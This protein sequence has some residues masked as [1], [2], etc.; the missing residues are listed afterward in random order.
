[1]K[2]QK[3]WL[4]IIILFLLDCSNDSEKKEI[5]FELVKGIL[6]FA[7]SEQT[8]NISNGLQGY[9]FDKKDYLFSINWLNNGLQLYDVG[10]EELIKEIRF[11]E[12]GPNGVGKIFG[13]YVH[14]FDSIFLFTQRNSEIILTDTSGI[15][16]N[17]ISYDPQVG[18]TNAFVHNSYFI[19]EPVIFGAKMIVKAHIEGNY[20]EMTQSNLQKFPLSYI[21]NL[22]TG[23]SETINATYPDDYMLEGMRFFEYSM[24]S[25]G[26]NL[27]FSF[28]GDH[29]VF[30]VEDPLD[31]LLSYSDSRSQYLDDALPLYPMNGG[32][33]DTYGYLFAS[34]HYESLL[35]DPF[36]EIYYRIAV[37]KVES[38]SEI[39][40]FELKSAPL[41][42]S[43]VVL[44]RNLELVGEY[45]FENQKYLPQNIF[46]G[47][48][49]L[50][51]STSHPSNKDIKEDFMVF[52]CLKVSF[53]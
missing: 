28:F 42:F 10:K 39:E 24:T 25:N 1:M 26:K 38:P 31:K 13:F 51:I 43:V 5:K 2:I 22:E 47:S 4:P 40:L 14:N 20:R 44:N 15:I 46:I 35:Y 21:I 8:S 12:Q 52:D 29:R 48:N 3:I 37:P 27:V 11:H 50:Y 34:D 53:L 17:K 32:R 41:K 9:S 23:E 30:F 7:I 18:F 36:K 33:N 16:K 6:T 19:S 49:G 45:L